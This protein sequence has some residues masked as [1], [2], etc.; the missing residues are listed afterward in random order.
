MESL[1]IGNGGKLSCQ[2]SSETESLNEVNVTL[3]DVMAVRANGRVWCSYLNLT[4]LYVMWL[5]I[6]KY[7]SLT[8]SDVF[9]IVWSRM[10]E[11]DSNLSE[12]DVR[13]EF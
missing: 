8:Y 7:F 9:T 12:S 2:K 13:V 1:D 3:S 5:A 4:G 6:T 11:P 10:L